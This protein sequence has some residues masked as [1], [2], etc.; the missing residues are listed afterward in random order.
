MAV[1][2]EINDTKIPLEDLKNEFNIKTENDKNDDNLPDSTPW[3]DLTTKQRVIYVVKNFL[4]PIGLLS[5]LYF[6]ICSLD[7]MSTSFQL[8]AGTF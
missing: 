6:F 4:R 5:C 8:I 2:Q 7:V 3:E 1:D